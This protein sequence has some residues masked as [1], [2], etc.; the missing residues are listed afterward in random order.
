VIRSCEVRQQR[1]KGES[2]KCQTKE[3]TIRIEYERG[4]A[5]RRPKNGERRLDFECVKGDEC[6]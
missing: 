2:D 3:H 6:R 1:R 4:G 5:E